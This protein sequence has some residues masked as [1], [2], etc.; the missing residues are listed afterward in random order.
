M[1]E[2]LYPEQLPEVQP[3]GF[4]PDRD[5][6]SDLGYDG[7]P[8][9]PGLPDDQ[10][11]APQQNVIGR[12]RGLK[13]QFDNAKGT[14]GKVK[15]KLG[16]RS[17][18]K[19]GM[20]E[21][22]IE[23]AKN[24][25]KVPPLSGAGQPVAKGVGKELAE[26]VGRAGLKVGGKLGA[27][28]IPILGEVLI[29]LDIKKLLTNKKF[30]TWIVC[31]IAGL[32][33]LIAIPL[34]LLGGKGSP[35]YPTTQAQTDQTTL[36]ASIGGDFVLSGRKVTEKVLATEKERY[37]FVLKNVGATKPE[38][39][40][41]VRLK[42]KEILLTIESGI[43]LSGEAKKKQLGE[44][45]SKIQALDST[46]PFGEWIAK[47]A[48][49]QVGQA[50]G[51][52]CTITKAGGRVACASFVST[53]LQNAG[54][55]NP[56]EAGVDGIWRRPFYKIVVSRPDIKSAGYYNQNKSKL[57]VGDIIFWGDGSCSKG[58][59]VLFDHIGFYIGGDEA[60]DNS[61]GGKDGTPPPQIRRRGAASRSSCIVFNGAKRYGS[62]L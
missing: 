55:P 33:L 32:L 59:S 61:S 36:V 12:R 16:A 56:I 31:I 13:S 1:P 40:A 21:P 41:E 51:N 62:D 19:A 24:L 34:G 8:T 35:Q 27:R 14:Y 58:G 29:A 42:V 50:S 2:V 23:G 17:A 60:I 10:Q 5:L 57:Q 25:K 18:D 46:L 52:F 11:G 28:L 4:D 3:D 15:G 49:D 22:G 6:L 30:W 48:K 45:I 26:D 20:I 39:V 37:D 47:E 53:V 44:A 54:I 43:N 7:P 38:R 9:E